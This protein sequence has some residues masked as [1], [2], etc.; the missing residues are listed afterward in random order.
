[1]AKNDMALNVK[2]NGDNRD[3]RQTL[4]ES[5]RDINQFQKKANS[6][7]SMSDLLVSQFVMGGGLSKK[8]ASI[9]NA[10]ATSAS[11]MY[12][13]RP[14]QNH[15]AMRNLVAARDISQRHGSN[16]QARIF[17]DMAIHRGHRQR[18]AIGRAR[19]A[20]T[21]LGGAIAAAPF[22]A[23]GLKGA[24]VAAA[25]AAAAGAALFKMSSF[26]RQQLQTSTQFSGTATLAQ[27]M[28]DQRDIQRQVEIGNS[29]YLMEQQKQLILSQERREQAGA[30]GLGYAGTE[31]EILFNDL[32]AGLKN[33]ASAV[34]GTDDIT[35]KGVVY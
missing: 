10:M 6:N 34:I 7:L 19:I 29:P 26:G 28:K 22:V 2:L 14:T 32:I 23:A 1:M 31:G 5:S 8:M 15:Q 30:V 13:K 35:A 24:G 16:R 17:H 12:M 27:A 9:G 11:A 33:L 4:K 3:F 21:A 25:I 18:K 20:N